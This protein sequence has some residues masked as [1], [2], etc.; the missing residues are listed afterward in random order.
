MLAGLLLRL[1]GGVAGDGRGQPAELRQGDLVPAPQRLGFR[2]P[3]ASG[4]KAMPWRRQASATAPTLWSKATV[5]AC[6]GS[7]AALAT[8]FCWSGW[9]TVTTC[10]VPGNVTVEAPSRP[11][12]HQWQCRTFSK[13]SDHTA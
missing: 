13:L 5:R 6:L 12:S 9:T 3:A 11:L 2:L 10:H 4:T 7:V 1:P 8:I